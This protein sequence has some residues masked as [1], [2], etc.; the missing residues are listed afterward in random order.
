MDTERRWRLEGELG[1]VK[2][3]RV[4]EVTALA[5]ILIRRAPRANQQR[6]EGASGG[7]NQHGVG[8]PGE[9]EDGLH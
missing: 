8:K 7:P 3:V 5:D 6:V 9:G 2:Q 4:A 1:N